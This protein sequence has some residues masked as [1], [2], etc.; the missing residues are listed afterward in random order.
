MKSMKMIKN[1]AQRG[2]TLIELMIVVAIIGILAAVAIPAYQDYT[3][4]SQI[5]TALAEITGGKNNIAGMLAQG[6]PSAA[7]ATALTGTTADIL[8]N[9]GFVAATSPRCSAYTSTIGSDGT[10]SISCTMI[11]TAAVNG[12][13]I[14]WSRAADGVWT[15]KISIADADKQLTP[16]NCTQDASVTA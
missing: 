9:F 4:K 3:G 8:K 15:C 11:G 10:A 13:F 14:K 5:G 1:Q 7:E 6:N 12:K 16:K 2:F